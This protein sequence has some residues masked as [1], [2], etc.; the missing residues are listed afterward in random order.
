[1]TYFGPDQ[2][3]PTPTPD[4]APFWAHCAQ[5]RLA[6]QRCAACGTLTHPPLSVCPSCQ[7]FARE[8][9]DAPSAAVVFSFT[10]VHTAAHDTVRDKV[11]YNVAVVE[12]PGLPGVRLVT[13]V[14]DATP[15]SLRVGEVVHL[16]WET[17][18]AMALP[19]FRRAPNASG[20]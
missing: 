2:V 13:N 5:R 17:V 11:P 18:G 12:F 20:A 19:R 9:S 7:S 3:L 10:W 1:M 4:D 6:F 14:V 16:A 8:W 15:G